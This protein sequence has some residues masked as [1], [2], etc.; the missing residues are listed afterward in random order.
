LRLGAALP[1]DC[2]KLGGPSLVFPPL[3]DSNSTRT[4]S[5]VAIRPDPEAK[6]RSTLQKATVHSGY[7]QII[8]P[9]QDMEAGLKM[10]LC[11]KGMPGVS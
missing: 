6:A 7:R 2:P 9:S 4:E 10:L 8:R 11:T 3:V 5:Y 1:S